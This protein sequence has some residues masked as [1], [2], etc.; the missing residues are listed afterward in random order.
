MAYPGR[1]GGP[2]STQLGTR[3]VPGMRGVTVHG[4]GIVGPQHSAIQGRQVE[5]AQP[6]TVFIQGS[7]VVISQR[8]AAEQALEYEI[9]QTTGMSFDENLRDTQRACS[10]ARVQDGV[11]VRLV[12]TGMPVALGTNNARLVTNGVAARN[13]VPARVGAVAGNIVFTR[14]N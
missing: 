7:P 5:I 11:P 12:A 3:E 14:G 9:W 2:P 6:T 1:V 8:T 13:G 10:P 4:T